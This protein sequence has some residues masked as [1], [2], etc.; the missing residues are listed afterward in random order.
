M[1]ISSL[2]LSTN[3]SRPRMKTIGLYS[4]S[5]LAFCLTTWRC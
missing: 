4:V 5:Q 2:G 1:S 3:K